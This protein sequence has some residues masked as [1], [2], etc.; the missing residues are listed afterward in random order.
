MIPTLFLWGIILFNCVLIFFL[1]PMQHTVILLVYEMKGV[2]L[3]LFVEDLGLFL[4]TLLWAIQKVQESTL[5]SPIWA[6]LYMWA[7]A[8]RPARHV[9]G[10]FR[11]QEIWTVRSVT[12]SRLS[13]LRGSLS[14]RD[15]LSRFVSSSSRSDRLSPS[16]H[17]VDGCRRGP[18]PQELPRRGQRGRTR[19]R[20]AQVN[21]PPSLSPSLSP[22]VGQSGFD[23]CP[24][25]RSFRSPAVLHCSL[26]NCSACDAADVEAASVLNFRGG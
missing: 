2:C 23:P 10:I 9:S 8:G 3:D 21:P 25:R 20:S 18:A 24:H 26:R 17:G 11:A 5:P 19:Q 6:E 13:P 22:L 14:P 1:H 4:P 15:A 7:V 12:D 16:L